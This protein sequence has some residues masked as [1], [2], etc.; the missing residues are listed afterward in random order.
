LEEQVER[1][2]DEGMVAQPGQNEDPAATGRRLLVATG[3]AVADVDEL[4]EFVRVLL[5]AA[6]SVLVITPILPS[7]LEWLVSDTDR[8]RHQADERLNTVMGQLAEL[9]LDATGMVADETPLTAFADAIREFEPSHIL[10]ALREHEH[11]GWQ[12]RGL[13]DEVRQ[14]FRLPLTVFDIDAEGHVAAPESD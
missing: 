1:A 8:A 2:K 11:A 12:E 7:R 13:V 5:D 4:P 9:G 14:R 6:R 10:I 3:A